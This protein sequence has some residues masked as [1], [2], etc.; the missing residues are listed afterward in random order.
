ML[1]I[2]I[3]SRVHATSMVSH[4]CWPWSDH[5]AEVVFV[6]FL[7]YS[8]SFSYLNI[9]YSERK[10]TLK[11]WK[12]CSSFL[13]MEYLYKLFGILHWRCVS[14]PHLL[15]SS[16]IYLLSY[17]Y[18]LADIRFILWIIIQ[19]YVIYFIAQILPAMVIGSSF[20]WL[21]CPFDM[22]LSLCV[23]VFEHFL[24]F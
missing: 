12:V 10:A 24:P 8:Y 18:G 16:I 19:H 3:I 1:Q 9:L 6:K 22:P 13:R 23:C 4:W 5:L 11:E 7:H 17:Q 20:T 21:L 14:S 15:T 2:N